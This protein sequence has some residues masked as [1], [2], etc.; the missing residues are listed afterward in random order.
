MR[1]AFGTGLLLLTLSGLATGCG[2][3]GSDSSDASTTVTGSGAST[4]AVATDPIERVA[5]ICVALTAEL[6]DTVQEALASTFELATS[7]Q[8]T[9]PDALAPVYESIEESFGA[10][11]DLVNLLRTE[12]ADI[13]APPEIE[14]ALTDADEAL[15]GAGELL[16][17][18]Q[19]AAADED[20]AGLG[21][22][23]DEIGSL[24]ATA[25]TDAFGQLADLG[26]EA[27]RPVD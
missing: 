7:V 9:T 20:L 16:T 12:F 8:S 19:E 26:A 14:Q 4:G 22:A 13:E 1:K 27:C 6:G 21:S 11:I 5:A 15:A 2:G 10:A 23:V 17:E 25:L 18:V 24:D 3:S